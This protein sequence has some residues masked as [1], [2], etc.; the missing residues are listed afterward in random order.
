MFKDHSKSINF[1]LELD[2]AT[3]YK[4]TKRSALATD[5]EEA[6][7][8]KRIP[9]ADKHGGVQKYCGVYYVACNSIEM[10]RDVLP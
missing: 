6:K 5:Y 3:D 7:R 8:R 10:R 1:L 2:V 9:F 4:E